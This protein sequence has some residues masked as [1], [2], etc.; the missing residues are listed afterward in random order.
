CAPMRPEGGGRA[1]S[2]R[3]RLRVANFARSSYRSL[4]WALPAPEV[5][6]ST[7]VE[8]SFHEKSVLSAVQGADPHP[9]IGPSVYRYG[10]E[11]HHQHGRSNLHRPPADAHL[12]PFDPRGDA[13]DRAHEA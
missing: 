11:S 4:P 5:E 10:P 8:P 7:S 3:A 13:A 1:A 6:L 12:E 2:R 9:R